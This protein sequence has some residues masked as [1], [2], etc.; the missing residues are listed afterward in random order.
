[1]PQPVQYVYPVT[2]IASAVIILLENLSLPSKSDTM[3]SQLP[4]LFYLVLQIISTY[5]STSIIHC[6]YEPQSMYTLQYHS[7]QN[8][9]RLTL[10]QN[11]IKFTIL[12]L[13]MAY[14]ATVI[15][16]TF[17][18]SCNKEKRFHWINPLLIQ[19]PV[20]LH[21]TCTITM[22]HCYTQTKLHVHL[23]G[24]MGLRNP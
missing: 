4:I 16:F 11:L 13:S 18:Q 22:H 14:T 1:M 8:M 7:H 23:M 20:I 9:F 2:L 19:S 10:I 12:L 3:A 15:N 21:Y 5:I 17:Y 24:S 6:N